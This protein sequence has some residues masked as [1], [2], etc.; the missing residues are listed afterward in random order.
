M[1]GKTEVSDT[2]ICSGKHHVFHTSHAKTLMII[3]WSIC[4]STLDLC[5]LNFSIS[6]F[7]L[8]SVTSTKCS[9]GFICD[10]KL[11]SSFNHSYGTP[12]LWKILGVLWTKYSWTCFIGLS[13]LLLLNISP[14]LNMTG[15]SF[16]FWLFSPNCFEKSHRLSF[17]VFNLE[18]V[19]K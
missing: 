18:C 7:D 1:Q 10:I 6:R 15:S 11:T 12:G 8:P 14:L 13:F 9:L 2:L 3:S 16:T 5:C 19:I 17:R 4:Y